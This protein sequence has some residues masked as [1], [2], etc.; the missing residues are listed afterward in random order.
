MQR[1][2]AL[3]GRHGA[4]LRLHQRDRRVLRSRPWPLVETT[5]EIDPRVVFFCSL[6]ARAMPFSTAGAKKRTSG[7]HWLKPEVRRRKTVSVRDFVAPRRAHSKLRVRLGLI[8]PNIGLAIWPAASVS[9]GQPPAPNGA[10]LASFGA[11]GSGFSHKLGDPLLAHAVGDVPL[12][13]S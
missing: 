9:Y 7:Q 13:L 8:V 10:G 4:L 11:H 1:A 2:D 3:A 5:R 12:G 6:V